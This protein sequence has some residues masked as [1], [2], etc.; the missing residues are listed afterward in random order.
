[1]SG[2]FEFD[3]WTLERRGNRLVYLNEGGA[4]VE[5]VEQFEFE[6]QAAIALFEA[7]VLIRKLELKPNGQ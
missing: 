3:P 7:Q 6:T 1:M 4:V 5:I 2:L